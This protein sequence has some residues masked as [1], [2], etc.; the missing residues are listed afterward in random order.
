M[1]EVELPCEF[2]VYP[3]VTFL[4]FIKKNILADHFVF[5]Q[6]TPLLG[7]CFCNSGECL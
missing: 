1:Q 2:V 6:S 7:H 5:N 3:K 4:S